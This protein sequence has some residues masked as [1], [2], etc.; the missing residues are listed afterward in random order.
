MTRSG[1]S[2]SMF[3]VAKGASDG[4]S[5]VSSLVTVDLCEPYDCY[6]I[7]NRV[8]ERGVDQEEK[9]GSTKANPIHQQSEADRSQAALRCG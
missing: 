9:P 3:P 1:V 5:S 4:C 8:D 7:L 6:R 2:Y